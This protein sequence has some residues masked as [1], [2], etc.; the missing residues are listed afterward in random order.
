MNC[1]LRMENNPLVLGK[2]IEL[3]NGIRPGSISDGY[4]TFD[5]LY[6]HRHSLF[7][8]VFTMAAKRGL[9]CG[10]SNRHSDG[11][12][13][14]GGGWNIVWIVNHF[15]KTEVRYHL[16]DS[17]ELDIKLKKDLGRVWN[18]KT[19]TLAALNDLYHF[20]IKDINIVSFSFNEDEKN[21]TYTLIQKLVIDGYKRDDNPIEP[22][23]DPN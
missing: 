1:W 18:G 7:L 20:L 22:H 17:I 21:E 14:F 16:P 19:E 23:I 12:L 3:P 15:T 6:L 13:C 4:H 10:W 5:E 8:I 2:D 11:E 9:E